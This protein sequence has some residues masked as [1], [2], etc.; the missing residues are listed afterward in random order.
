M[1]FQHY[2]V[3]PT[4]DTD[5]QHVSTFA[6]DVDTASFALAAGILR[7]NALPPEAA[8]RVEEFLNAFDY[9]YKPPTLQAPPFSVTTDVLPSPHRKGYHVLRIGLKGRALG[10]KKRQPASLTF[11][12]DTSSTMGRGQ[13]LG[14]VKRALR[15]LVQ[16]L[17]KHDTVAI[18]AYSSAARVV[19]PP[20][21]GSRK[22]QILRALAQLTP[23]GSA[24]AQAGLQ[25]GFEQAAGSFRQGIN[26]VLL[27][28]DGV[29]DS[30]STS[31]ETILR[32][33]QKHIRR[34][35]TLTAV[36]VGMGKYND[37]LLE[38]L[39]R[40]A[41]GSYHYVDHLSQAQ[42]IF[43][44]KLTGTLQLVARDV[45]L[46][47][48]F[49]KRAVS[50]YRLLGYEN[51]MLRKRDFA[52]SRVDGGEL[53][54]GQEVTALY[55]VRLRPTPLAT[56]LGSLRIRYRSPSGTP[57][58]PWHGKLPSAAARST[59]ARAAPA[60]RLAVLVA[61]F[62]EKLRRSYWVRNLSYGTL[63]DLLGKIRGP[64]GRRVDVAS[65]RGLVKRAEKLDRR[66][67]KYAQILPL[68]RMTFDRVPV[69]R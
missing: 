60:A 66:G 19:L 64:L 31:A 16:R 3:N 27:C 41:N 51:R 29:I 62:A 57:A 10:A 50:R 44:E 58:K 15:L 37:T 49:D 65:L 39:A 33:L 61:A 36:G 54:A 47:V 32:G 20:T 63:F 68:S 40:G 22:A 4:I 59:F 52:K 14:L 46:Q 23:A 24:N 69:L 38:Q 48:I 7:R 12:I 45:K 11:V 1:V 17:T 42:R 35:I 34:G 28:S 26:R 30:G 67:D 6:V 25:L 43:V 56:P 2:G 18:V 8:I 55:E 5:E 53:G 9:G 21:P 13:R